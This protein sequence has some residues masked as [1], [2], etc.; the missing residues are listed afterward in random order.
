LIDDLVTKGVSAGDREEPYR[1]FTSRAEYRLL[2]REDNADLRLRGEGRAIGLV[3]RE[4]HKRFLKKVSE[5]NKLLSILE[6]NRRDGVL[7]GDLLR[8]PGVEIDDLVDRGRFDREVLEQASIQV[9]YDGYLRRQQ[10]EVDRLQDVEEMKIPERFSYHQIPGLS[11]EVIEKLSVIQPRS[12]GQASRI[13]GITPS[14]IQI[15]AL[16]VNK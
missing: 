5:I 13:S 6:G 15:L 8:R 11:R 14:A 4:E 16:L 9:K 2:L 1:M 3:S 10:G 7:L 12:V